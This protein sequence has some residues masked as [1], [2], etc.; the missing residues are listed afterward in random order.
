M[1]LSIE[2]C[3][4]LFFITWI[5][6]VEFELSV[7]TGFN[8]VDI[9]KLIRT[10]SQPYWKIMYNIVLYPVFYENKNVQLKY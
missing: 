8:P 7:I 4:L 3:C 10:G 1:I 5:E 6:L 2:M 9:I